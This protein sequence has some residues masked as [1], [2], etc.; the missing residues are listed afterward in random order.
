M[1]NN[2]DRLLGGENVAHR[3]GGFRKPD[4]G[5]GKDG[6]EE[7]IG[8]GQIAQE[9][10]GRDFAAKWAGPDGLVQ[11]FEILG[12]ERIG[13]PCGAAGDEVEGEGGDGGTEKQGREATMGEC[14]ADEE[15]GNQGEAGA[16][17]IQRVGGVTKPSGK[18]TA[19]TAS[20]MAKPR[21]PGASRAPQKNNAPSG[22]KFG[23]DSGSMLPNTRNAT[24]SP[25]IRQSGR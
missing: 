19:H 7:Q 5:D 1:G 23:W 9:N 12:V 21:Q 14:L 20:G 22:W 24:M 11:A 15:N 13:D 8:G 18:V 4:L 2:E 17:E 6:G 10:P 16:R 3:K 25:T